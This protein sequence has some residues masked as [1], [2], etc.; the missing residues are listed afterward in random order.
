MALFTRLRRR[1]QPQ[2]EAFSDA[3]LVHAHGLYRYA[4]RLVRE[5]ADAED[6]VQ[7]TMIKA[8]RAFDRLRPNTNHRAWVFTI[9]RN[10]WLSRQRKAGREQPLEDPTVLPDLRAIHP[11][12]QM[13]RREDGYR[14]GFDD[15]VLRALD[16][17]PEPQRTAIVLCDVEGM[18]Y[19]EIADVM[20][21]PVGTV[22]SRIHHARRRLREGLSAYARQA[23]Y[24]GTG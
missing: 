16:R 8:L 13:V 20:T 10:T 5:P 24:G 2:D 17:L 18:S 1:P 6:L 19:E 7:E 23:G 15:E 4:T 3:V 9:L 11:A 12:V 14:H 21:C 22:R